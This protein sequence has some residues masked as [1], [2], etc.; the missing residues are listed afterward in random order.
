VLKP[1][2]SI[3]EGLARQVGAKASMGRLCRW[4]IDRY[5]RYLF[6]GVTA[7]TAVDKPGMGDFGVKGDVWISPEPFHQRT[8][9]EDWLPLL[10]CL[11]ESHYIF[12]AN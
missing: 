9:G 1:D 12:P 3:L 5:C 7:A 2:F 4:P 10:D 11:C 6:Q 8:F